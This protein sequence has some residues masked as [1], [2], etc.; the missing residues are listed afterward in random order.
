ME[1]KD[2]DNILQEIGGFRV[3]PGQ[4]D[5]GPERGRY[6]HLGRPIGNTPIGPKAS[7]MPK[8]QLTPWQQEL[9]DHILQR[10]SDILV[11]VNPAGGKTKP[12][13]EAWQESYARNGEQRNILWVTPTIQL[14]NQVYTVDLKRAITDMIAKWT[15]NPAESGF[16]LR[17]L[18]P[19]LQH[20]MVR[21][22]A[23]NAKELRITPEI[24]HELDAW[25]SETLMFFKAR[26]N[27]IG[28]LSNN[29]I[30]ATC[31]FPYAVEIMRIQKPK[32]LVIDELQQYVPINAHPD[33]DIQDQAKF[34]VQMMENIPRDCMLIFLTGS[35]N[36]ITAEQIANFMN[37]HFNRNVQVFQRSASNR[38]FIQVIPHDK[39]RTKDDI[40]NIAKQAVFDR[41]I[42]SAMALF[43][44]QSSE[45]AW[46]NKRAILPIAM[47]LLEKLP[48]KSIKALT[49]VDPI[50]SQFDAHSEP[51]DNMNLADAAKELSQQHLDPQ[52]WANHLNYMLWVGQEQA[53]GRMPVPRDEFGPKPFPDP[54]LARCLLS[55]FGYIAGGKRD[56]SAYIPDIMLTQALFKEGKIHFLFATDMIGVGTTLQIRKLYLPTLNKFDPKQGKPSPMD[57]S[58]LVQLINRVG[59]QTGISATVYCSRD[60]HERIVRS[61]TADPSSNVEPA[62]FGDGT[63][64]IEKAL[65]GKQMTD[66]V[67]LLLRAIRFAHTF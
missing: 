46:R 66:S 23:S 53:E 19:G 7:Y 31:T 41:E 49:G 62:L 15:N 27:P 13:V 10:R 21:S 9:K 1:K 6:A 30:A 35:M 57:T 16:P 38:A 20:E 44:V 63:S 37:V 58:T 47:S 24:Y 11:N 48:Q 12:C 54:I 61:L 18:P 4:A 50:P 22:G 39:M 56:R 52:W 34:F 3:R 26:S 2:I 33:D 64:G 59:R 25:V 36:S 14:A 60:E 32:I 28:R 42:G 67:I 5:P 65:K 40:V 43:S 55:G 29:T 17:L 45:P 51:R 8:F